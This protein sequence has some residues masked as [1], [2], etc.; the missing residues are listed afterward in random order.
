MNKRFVVDMITGAVIFYVIAI[1]CDAQGV[2]S[3]TPLLVKGVVIVAVIYIVGTFAGRGI[4][5]YINQ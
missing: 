1:L 2:F 5:Y 4:R 3:I